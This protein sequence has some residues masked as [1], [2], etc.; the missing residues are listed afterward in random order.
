MGLEVKRALS[1]HKSRMLT[2]VELF[3]MLVEIAT[4]GDVD[5]VMARVPREHLAAFRKWVHEL[6][7]SREVINVKTGPLSE[8]AYETM[9]SI[10]RW[11]DD[12]DPDTEV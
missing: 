3:H 12:H 7:S 4:S 11:L 2:D 10:C 5:Q 9:T 8:R 1:L 6:L